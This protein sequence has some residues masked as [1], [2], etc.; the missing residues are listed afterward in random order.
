MHA[1][2]GQGR[3]GKTQLYG[4]RT[5]SFGKQTSKFNLFNP[6]IKNIPYVDRETQSR[7]KTC[8]HMPT[9]LSDVTH[10]QIFPTTVYVPSK[11]S[12]LEKD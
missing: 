6:P 8:V 10:L 2:A 5:F 3:A 11:E 1:V 12:I 9:Y 7:E 4:T